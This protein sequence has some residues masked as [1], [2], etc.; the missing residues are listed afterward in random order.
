M[1][2]RAIRL[3]VKGV[4][5][6]T[7]ASGAGLVAVKY[8]M[9]AVHHNVGIE[10][11]TKQQ[12]E[13][14]N[15]D[16]H[17]LFRYLPKLKESIAWRQL[18]IFPTPIHYGKH[19]YATKRHG[20]ARFYVKREDLSSPLYGGNKVR[21]L[22][23]QLAICE[24]KDPQKTIY[25][26]GT[27]GSNQIIATVV[28]G[29]HCLKLNVCPVWVTKDVPN[30]DNTLNM[31]STLSF[32]NDKF[33]SWADNLKM[34]QTILSNL[35]G[36]NAFFLPPGGNNPAGVLGQVGGLLELAEQIQNNEVPDPDGIF[37]AMGSSCTISGI[38]IGVALC[39]HLQLNVFQ[40]KSFKIHGVPIHD[41]MA[42]ANRTMNFFKA[43]WSQY[44]P[45]SIRHSIISTCNE[46]KKAGG[47][48]LTHG[49]LEV[50]DHHC[51]IL[52]DAD[53]VGTY[54]GHSEISK[55]VAVQYDSMN[56]SIE[57]KSGKVQKPLW[58]CGHFTAKAFTHMIAELKKDQTKN[59]I[60]WQTKSA[61]QP[62]GPEDEW[63]KMKVLPD[64]IKA[65][66]DD[67]KSE[68]IRRPGSVNTRMG[69]AATYRHLM[70]DIDEVISDRVIKTPQGHDTC[71]I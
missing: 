36:K 23:H 43:S 22:Q 46:L 12:L 52:D 30:L 31:L 68:S 1:F 5:I 25:V 62:R 17:A 53:I 24:A 3:V 54:G 32:H 56:D 63:Q 69:T 42:N 47:P 34:F 29:L 37:L 26:T 57:D 55:N 40:V 59:F 66:A 19:K 71:R 70:T 58:L 60:F 65:W 21:T 20:T 10:K 28:H 41:G 44:V 4:A 18:G 35:L 50:F 2:R 15:Q 14:E 16:T 6:V 11:P 45:L 51:E 67:G 8:I 33:L 27:A 9:E 13:E 38:I 61:V 48:D 64:T 49:A 7:I 39:K